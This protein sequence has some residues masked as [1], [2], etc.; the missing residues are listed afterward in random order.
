MMQRIE[1]TADEISVTTTEEAFVSVFG[2]VMR[3]ASTYV[4]T[5]PWDEVYRVSFAVSRYYPDDC[6]HVTLTVD[7]IYGEYVEVASDAEG[8][9][10]AMR[11]FCR[12]SGK[13]VPDLDTPGP[14]DVEIWP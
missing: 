7:L 11:E 12:L 3:P 1:V 8:F 2:K 10:E 5:V 13:P 14:C 4:S 9:P 6:R